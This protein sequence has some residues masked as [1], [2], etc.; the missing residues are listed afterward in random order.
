[1]LPSFSATFTLYENIKAVKEAERAKGAIRKSTRGRPKNT[2]KAAK[3][4]KAKGS[5][6]KKDPIKG[7]LKNLGL[8]FSLILSPKILKGDRLKPHVSKGVL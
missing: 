4:A 2:K 3:A 8:G 1:V 5:K 6:A 7:A